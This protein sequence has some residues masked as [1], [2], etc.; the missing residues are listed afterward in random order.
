MSSGEMAS[1]WI[2]ISSLRRQ[3]F[4]MHTLPMDLFISSPGRYI[5]IVDGLNGFV[6][7]PLA[8]SS[9]FKLVSA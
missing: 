2:W 9:W 4:A 1:L 8:S 7:F 3:I 6:H 5:L